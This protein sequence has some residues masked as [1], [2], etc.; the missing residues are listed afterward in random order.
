MYH[1]KFI[2]LIYFSDP[3]IAALE[4]GRG[5]SSIINEG[6]DVYFNCMVDANPT[7]YKIRWYHEVS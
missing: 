2:M 5:A 7:T 1:K 3:P 6:A 4:L